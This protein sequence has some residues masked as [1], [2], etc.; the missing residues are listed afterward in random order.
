MPTPVFGANAPAK[1]S[2]ACCFLSAQNRLLRVERRRQGS[3]S[4]DEHKQEERAIT[5]QCET[6]ESG[7][8]ATISSP[9]THLTPPSILSNNKRDKQLLWSVK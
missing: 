2:A 5:T 9:K 7:C 8:F 1:R 3:P 4:R 6:S